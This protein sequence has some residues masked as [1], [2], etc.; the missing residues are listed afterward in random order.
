M[1][2]GQHDTQRL[3]VAARIGH[4]FAVKTP[5]IIFGRVDVFDVFINTDLDKMGEV[6]K[7]G[8]AQYGIDFD[9]GFGVANNQKLAA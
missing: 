5:Q 3:S 9:D 8:I 4:K 7:L 1:A 2:R 6:F